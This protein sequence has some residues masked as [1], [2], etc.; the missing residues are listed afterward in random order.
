MIRLLKAEEIEVRAAQVTEKGATWLLYKTARTDM[1]ILDETFGPENWTNDYKTVKDNMY[2]GIGVKFDNEWV[3]KWDCGTESNTEAEKGEASDSFKR[4]GFRWGIGR[5]LY[6][7]PFIWI[8]SG[9]DNKVKTDAV[10]EVKERNG[11]Y[12]CYE[13]LDVADIEYDTNRRISYLKIVNS[14]GKVVY[15]FGTKQ[16][17]LEERIKLIEDNMTLDNEKIYYAKIKEM[18]SKEANPEEYKKITAAW[19]K[20]HDSLEKQRTTTFLASEAEAVN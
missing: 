1:D 16:L 11:K 3:W 15:E 13:K 10:I 17:S 5:E 7:A 9:L 14:K 18:Y 19:T 4:A 12:A 2:C 6:T 20:K 8:S